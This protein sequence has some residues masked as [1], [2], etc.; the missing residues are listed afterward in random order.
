MSTGYWREIVQIKFTG[1]R[2][3]DH[4]LD[5]T[6]LSELA[7]FQEMIA[8]TAK[9]MWRAANPG[10][11]RLP[12]HF[13]DRTRLCLR[14]IGEGSVIVPLEVY[15]EKPPQ[16]GL[17]E[18]EPLEALQ[19]VD[20]A[21]EVYRALAQD[22]T[23]PLG[24]PRSLIPVYQ[25][26]GQGLA[27]E[28]EMELLREGVAMAS[29]TSALR[30][31]LAGYA[32]TPHQDQVDLVGEV[33]EADLRRQSFQLWLND[34]TGVPVSFSPDQ[35]EEVTNALRDHRRLRLRVKGRAEFSAQGAPLRV[36]A[37][38]ELSVQALGWEFDPTARPIED[39]LEELA[40]QVPDEEWSLLPQDLSSNLDY[41]LY[42]EGK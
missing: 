26:W 28:E 4:A 16:P 24:F 3:R 25:R 27:A 15:L 20:L 38:S 19:A 2:F 34:R 37:V 31:R 10:R 42:G 23:L 40:R 18:P 22:I 13:E 17:F 5:I 1:D 36:F 14:S 6:A 39:V 33:L 41:Y 9:A 7:N 35:E 8:E 29:V 11:E 30:E 32:E 12:A 21:G